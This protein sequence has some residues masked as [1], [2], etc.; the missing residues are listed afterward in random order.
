MLKSNPI[1]KPE[2]FSLYFQNNT[3]HFAR[4]DQG[5]PVLP[6]LCQFYYFD[7]MYVLETTTGFTILIQTG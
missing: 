1:T 3:D 5:S 4:R 7:K 2:Y 6:K